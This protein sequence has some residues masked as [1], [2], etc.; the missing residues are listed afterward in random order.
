MH[1]NVGVGYHHF[2]G[3]HRSEATSLLLKASDQPKPWDP[4]CEAIAFT[5]TEALGYLAL[6]IV[7]AGA[8]IR[9]KLCS[10]GE[11]LLYYRQRRQRL[12]S[13]KVDSSSNTDAAVFVTWEMCWERLESKRTEVSRDA[14]ELLNILAFLHWENISPATF[15]RALANPAKEK[16]AENEMGSSGDAQTP[17]SWTI[18]IRELARRLLMYPIVNS[19]GPPALPGILRE[20]ASGLVEAGDAKYRVRHALAELAHLS[21]IIS[22]EHNDT[23]SMHPLVHTWVRERPRDRLTD[24]TRRPP[25]LIDDALFA[26]MTGRL[27][28]ASILLPPLGASQEDQDYHISLLPHIEH[29]QEQRTSIASAMGEKRLKSHAQPRAMLSVWITSLVP[30]LTPDIPLLR[31]NV[32]F[33]FVY[34]QCGHFARAET[35]LFPVVS[36]LKQ[37]LG[38]QDHKTIAASLFLSKIYWGLGQAEKAASLQQSVLKT[39]Q[40]HFGPSHFQTLRAMAELGKTRWQQGMYSAAR[41][42]QVA[43]LRELTE[44]HQ[45][46]K[47]DPRVL[48]AMDNLALT[49]HKFWEDEDFEEAFRLHSDAAEGMAEVHGAHH[50]RTLA[51]VEN[52]C[53]VAVLLGGQERLALARERMAEVL[54]VRKRQLGQDHPYTLLAMVNMAIVLGA[55]GELEKAEGLIREGLPVADSTLGEEHIG[56]LF[57]RHT[58]ACVIAE[59]G[60]H[61]E[62]EKL[63]WMVTETQKR[64]GSHRGAYHPDR[65]GALIELARCSFTQGK[66]AEAVSICSEAIKG[67]EQITVSEKAHPLTLKLREARKQMVHMMEGEHHVG[68]P[69]THQVKFPF[70]LFRVGEE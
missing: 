20:V 32:K 49:V 50:E 64:M 55:V 66:V 15:D 8:A 35:L 25:R 31:M 21:L 48:E 37:T 1:G 17:A 38:P 68:L 24:G 14:L 46:G 5:I 10:L 19:R 22:N 52:S 39:S 40:R 3:L 11:Y 18:A 62:A 57:G 70:V 26:E 47:R 16:E 43:V 4:K 63:L 28:S 12:L 44:T 33:A 67:F 7:H 69:E 65:L 42:L 2:H 54:E 6:A 27:L 13:A 9:D 30:S 61:G 60:R 41:D 23:Y 29:V 53:R 45:L 34:F 59:R 36:A 51:A 56:T 58:L